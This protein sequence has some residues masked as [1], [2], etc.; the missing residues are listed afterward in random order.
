[1][2]FTNTIIAP[3]VQPAALTALGLFVAWSVES[4]VELKGARLIGAPALVG[5]TWPM[6]NGHIAAKRM[7][8][9][10]VAPMRI[11]RAR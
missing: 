6:G 7:L 9:P 10:S 4:S 5:H 8:G 1:M 3:S 2:R 11:D